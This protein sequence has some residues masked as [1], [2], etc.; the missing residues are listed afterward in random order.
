MDVRMAGGFGRAFAAVAISRIPKLCTRAFLEP[1]A[2][3]EPGGVNCST[4]AMRSPLT[5]RVGICRRAPQVTRG[6]D[7]TDLGMCGNQLQ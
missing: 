2:T 6:V 5:G 3:M 4:I 7:M 1:G